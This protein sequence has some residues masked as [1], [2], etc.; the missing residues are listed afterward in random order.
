MD[1]EVIIFHFYLTITKYFSGWGLVPRGDATVTQTNISREYALFCLG[2]YVS[3][4][5]GEQQY[6][7][8]NDLSVALEGARSNALT[9]CCKDLGIASELWDPTFIRSFKLKNCEA[10]WVEHQVTKKK[11]LIWRLKGN[12]VDYP[13]KLSPQMF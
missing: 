9:R 8:K 4:A 5:R 11:R 10:V 1:L 2:Q 7:D 13:Y 3:Q 6:F 12:P